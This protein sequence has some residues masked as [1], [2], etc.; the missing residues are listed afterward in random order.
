MD[1]AIRE[2]LKRAF[3]AGRQAQGYLVVGPVRHEGREL[4]EWIGTQLL[5]NSSTIHEH[6]HPDMPWF[7]P[8]KKSRIIGIDMMRTRILDMAQQSSLSGGWKVPVIVSAERMNAAAANAF[9]KTLEEPPPKTLFL[10]L[11][12]SLLD[13]LPTIVSRCQVIAVGGTRRL[14]EPWRTQVLT[15]LA[16]VTE[17]SVL[18][19]TARAECLSAILDEM[20]ERAEEQVR[21]EIRANAVVELDTDTV[22]ALTGAQAKAWRMD[23]LFTVEQW[24]RDM[25][26]V[27]VAGSMEEVQ[28]VF[29]EYR[30][31][32][33][34]RV[35]K[36]PLAKLLE[37]LSML[38]MLETHL[39]RNLS[40]AQILP[41]WMDRFYL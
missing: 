23:L 20:N 8:E 3:D 9:L 2:G 22:S 11:V 33:A 18:K 13:V 1:D 26:R 38:E 35:Q 5:G 6:V 37:N 19:D 36:Y 30:E 4:A 31:V 10:L 16:G 25:I 39:E 29:P 27:H 24:M 21:S 32:L 7:E 15:L 12:D 40:P 28:L 14:E 17:K 34:T 41:Y